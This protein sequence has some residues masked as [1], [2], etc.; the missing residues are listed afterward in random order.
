MTVY[1]GHHRLLEVLALRFHSCWVNELVGI[2]NPKEDLITMLAEGGSKLAVIPVL[3][4]GGLGKTT[5]ARKVY[6]NQQVGFHFQCHAWITVSHTLASTLSLETWSWSFTKATMSQLQKAS[7]PLMTLYS[8]LNQWNCIYEE[9][10]MYIFRLCLAG[11]RLGEFHS[12]PY[13]KIVLVVE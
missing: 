11:N 6:E 13:L 7:W 4:M 9:R 10:G 2:E 12:Y 1:R 3:R 8:W 5:L